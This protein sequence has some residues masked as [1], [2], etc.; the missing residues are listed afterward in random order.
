MA[1]QK[2]SKTSRYYKETIADIEIEH[3]EFAQELKKAV[4]KHQATTKVA[5]A[6]S[7]REMHEN[8][9]KGGD[10]KA[11]KIAERDA[12]WKIITL[13]IKRNNTD[14]K[15]KEITGLLLKEI[16]KRNHPDDGRIPTEPTM[17]K[18]VGKWLRE[19]R[20]STFVEVTK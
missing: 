9:K 20:Q 10:A 12:R 8:P 11:A 15:I 1:D 17:Q 2:T 5:F 19:E 4:H 14:M 7:G 16:A 13:E 3:F 18:L 6:K